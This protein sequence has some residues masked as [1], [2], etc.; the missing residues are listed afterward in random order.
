MPLIICTVPYF[1]L[2]GGLAYIFIIRSITISIYTGSKTKNQTFDKSFGKN[3]NETAT[4]KVNKHSK[5]S[6]HNKIILFLIKQFVPEKEK[7][8]HST[9]LL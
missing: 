5:R 8:S 6:S 2:F 1:T 4:T 3:K 9:I 7:T